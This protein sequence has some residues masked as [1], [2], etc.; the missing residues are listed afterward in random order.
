MKVLV[1][2][3]IFCLCL[4]F[5]FPAFACEVIDD[6]GHVVHLNHPA[7]RIISL[8]PDLTELLF[9]AGAGP[10]IVG[11]MQGSDYPAAAKKIPLVAS[12][13][14][15]NSE[16]VLALHPD[17]VV[18]WAGGSSA[19]QLQ[20]LKTMGIPVFLSHQH[21][22][23]DIPKTL[24]KLGCL[25]G[26]ETTANR[27]AADFLQ[28]YQDLQHRYSHLKTIAVFYEM[29]PHP[30]ITVNKDSWINQIIVLCGGEN[31][32]ASAR[33]VAP[34][35]S[36]EAVLATNPT[37]II[38]TATTADWEEIWQTWPQLSAVKNQFIYPIAPDWLE[39]AGPRLL[40]GAAA[41]CAD[42][43]HARHHP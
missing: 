22:L 39:R 42:I 43:D 38:S 24:Q 18:A 25:A 32:F 35:V 21:D 1:K 15:L 31:I 2:I 37:V 23:T 36:M 9:A 7:K 20:Q 34:Q 3:V 13:N 19:A 8:A 12:Y 30:L 10:S 29:W 17:L 27:A 6:A 33:G 11:V 14:R 5:I 28:R 16:A 4:F 41:V 26:T 40:N